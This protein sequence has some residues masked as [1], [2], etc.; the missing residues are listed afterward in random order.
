MKE[1]TANLKTFGSALNVM[2]RK[3]RNINGESLEHNPLF[4]ARP[5][6][7]FPAHSVAA[8]GSS[9]RDPGGSAE[10]SNFPASGQ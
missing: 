3:R 6:G 9:A 10:G 7:L 1:I 2:K 4:P 8:T 5:L